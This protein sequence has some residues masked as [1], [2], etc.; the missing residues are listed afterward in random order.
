MRRRPDGLE[1]PA[2]PM[3]SGNIQK[4]QESRASARPAEPRVSQSDETGIH[5]GIQRARPRRSEAPAR[6]RP[7]AAG[8]YL[9]RR[10]RTYYFR[11]RLPKVIAEK[12]GR[13]FLRLSLRT[14]LRIDAMSRAARLVAACH[15]AERDVMAELSNQP[16]APERITAI[17]TETLRVELARILAEQDRGPG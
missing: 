17:L 2:Q 13:T 16:M 9:I 8:P 1:L 12:C 11:K 5:C 6:R 14:P 15:A 10:G 3:T 4:H 7:A